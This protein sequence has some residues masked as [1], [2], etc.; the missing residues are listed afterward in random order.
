M[1]IG[2]QIL[3]L[4][5][6]CHLEALGVHGRIILNVVGRNRMGGRGLDLRGSGLE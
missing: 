1:S 6:R 2:F 3:N 4:K 5:K